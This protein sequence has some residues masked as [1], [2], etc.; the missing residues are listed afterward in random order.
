MRIETLSQP[1]FRARSVNQT[2]ASF[3]S[4]VP[5]LTEPVGDAA[6]ATGASVIDFMAGGEGT[7]VQN[8]A[9]IVPYGTGADTNTFSVRI[10]AWKPFGTL[11]VPVLLAELLCTLSSGNPGAGTA[12]PSTMLFAETITLTHGNANVSIDVVSPA[13]SGV[14]AHALL[15]LKGATKIELSF[16]TG[17]SATDCNALIAVL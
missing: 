4:K 10:I 13:A 14:I 12:I 7:F 1:Y 17:S 3:V 16:Q 5:T 8:G 6:T 11:W 15:D 2:S 9:M